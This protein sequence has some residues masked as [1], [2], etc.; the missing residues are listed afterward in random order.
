MF[1]EMSYEIEL[2]API[3]RFLWNA[4][5][6]SPGPNGLPELSKLVIE[7][8]LSDRNRSGKMQFEMRS[9]LALNSR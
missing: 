8:S 9:V 2:P 1:L 3:L 6:A 5:G 7:R 4:N